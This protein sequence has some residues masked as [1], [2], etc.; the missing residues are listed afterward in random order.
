MFQYFSEH[1]VRLCGKFVRRTVIVYHIISL[2]QIQM[3]ILN[4]LHNRRNI[5]SISVTS[6]CNPDIFIGIH[7]HR[8]I[9]RPCKKGL[10]QCNRGFHAH[11]RP[12][13]GITAPLTSNCSQQAWFIHLQTSISWAPY[14]AVTMPA[15]QLPQIAITIHNLLA[16]TLAMPLPW[17]A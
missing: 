1:L 10:V 4:S 16:K 15:T 14:S 7:H 17:M 2:G 9:I 3:L 11:K 6:S 8:H 13:S 12:V 5:T